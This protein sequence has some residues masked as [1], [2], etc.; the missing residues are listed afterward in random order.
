VEVW[1][2][3]TIQVTEGDADDVVS[4]TAWLGMER[5]LRGTVRPV[6]RPIG[7]TQLGSLA[8]VVS[9]ALSSGGAGSVLASSLITWLRTRPT[10]A[11]LLVTAGERTVELDIRTLEEV[12]PLLEQVLN[13][14]SQD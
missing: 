14:A 13:V 9:V 3:V 4:L 8:E 1:V 11:K 10:R 12:R 6:S 5:E 7:Q 2:D